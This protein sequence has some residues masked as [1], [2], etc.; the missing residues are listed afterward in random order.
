MK[1]GDGAVGDGENDDLPV[2]DRHDR[3]AEV[4]IIFSAHVVITNTTVY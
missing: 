3:G 4:A 2:N 1:T